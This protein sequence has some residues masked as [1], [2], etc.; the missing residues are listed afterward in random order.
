MRILP[1][2]IISVLLST[3]SN[4]TSSFLTYNRYI[5]DCYTQVV[6][7][8]MKLYLRT[9]GDIG[10]LKDSRSINKELRKRKLKVNNVL[11]CGKT[12]IE[13]YYELFFMHNFKAKLATNNPEIIK[14]DTVVNNQQFSLIGVPLD[15]NKYSYKIDCQNIFKS[16]VADS[17]YSKRIVTLNNLLEKYSK[18]N[19]F[20]QALIDIQDYPIYNPNDEWFK[21]QMQLTYASFLGANKEYFDL[22]KKWESNYHTDSIVKQTI[23]E[24]SIKGFDATRELILKEAQYSKLV[25]FNEN[26]FYPNH[27]KLVLSLLKDFKNYGFKYLALETLTNDSALNSGTSIDLN[28]GFYTREPNYSDLIRT[29]QSLGFKFVAYESDESSARREEGQAQNL[30]NKT[31]KIDSTAKVLVIAGIS[32]IFELPDKSKK[33]WMAS[34]FKNKYGIDPTTFNQT[35]LNHY[36]K[37]I[38]DIAILKSTDLKSNYYNTT[39]WQIINNLPLNDNFGNFEYKNEYNEPVQLSLFPDKELEGKKWTE[40]K[41]P[42]RCY[43][44]QKGETYYSKVPNSSYRLVILDKNGKTLRNEIIN[45]R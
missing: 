33:V 10:F 41:V 13:P 17:S 34:I 4:K 43:L 18:S 25:M 37:V 30:Y 22:I 31:F 39:D 35:S 8:S 26:H 3:C 38:D 40:N 5:S 45:T 7:D 15:G 28:T 19:H 29:A 1:L 21:L 11:V 2:I 32:H 36:R 24:K 6:N 23:E 14:L 27:R 9:P 16:I 44:L 42:F 20:Y 12:K